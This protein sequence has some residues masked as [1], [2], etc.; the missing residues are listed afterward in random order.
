M[1]THA[2]LA[3]VKLSMG[4][5]SLVFIETCQ[6]TREKVYPMEGC[7]LCV[8]VVDALLV[9][10]ICMLAPFSCCSGPVAPGIHPLH[11]VLSVLWLT[12]WCQDTWSMP[13]YVR[14]CHKG[15]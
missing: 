14:Y 5:T 15:W 3:S 7:L 8:G 10:P 1:A 4:C 2:D 12:A 9:A 6:W 13:L 11:A